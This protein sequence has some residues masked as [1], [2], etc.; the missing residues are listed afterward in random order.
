[1]MMKIAFPVLLMA[2]DVHLILTRISVI[3]LFYKENSQVGPPVMM[4]LSQAC[5]SLC[6]LSDRAA[7]AAASLS[8]AWSHPKRPLSKKAGYPIMSDPP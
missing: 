3:L 7:L 8:A 6:Y 5:Q 4:V 1:M 2:R